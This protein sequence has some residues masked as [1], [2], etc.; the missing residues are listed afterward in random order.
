[1]YSR[2]EG[3]KNVA[4]VKT[5]FFKRKLKNKE[6]KIEWATQES[7]RTEILLTEEPGF[8]VPEDG[9]KTSRIKQVDLIKSVDITNATK[10][11]DLN[12]QFGIYRMNFTRNGRHLLIGGRK[13]H[14][15][16][17]DWITKY[18]HCEMNVMEEVFDVQWLHIETMFAVAQKKWLYIYDNT[19]IELH[20]LKTINKPLRLEFLPYHFLLISGSEEG[21]LTWLDISV[22]SIVSQFNTK[23]GRL[24][25]MKQNPY[26][27]ILC[28]GHSKGIVAMWSPNCKDPVAKILCHRTPLSALAVDP[29]GLYMATSAVDHH[30]NIWDIRNLR[31]P[32]Q[33]YRLHSVASELAFSQRSS[34]ALAMGNIVEIY[35]DCCLTNVKYPYMRHRL[36]S[37]IGNIEFC[38]YEDVLGIGHQSGYTSILIPGSGEPNIDALEC[39]PFQTKKQRQEAEVK[40]LLEKIQPEMI[41]LNPFDILEVNVATSKEKDKARNKSF[42]KKSGHNL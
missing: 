6:K 40:A 13:G 5:K 36:R 42:Q 8:L 30:M 41:S 38:P 18:L 32:L 17:F 15:A 2:G 24:S 37:R 3:L 9:E 31:G 25:I 19:G 11:F 28:T 27:A 39:N 16:S 22:G 34:L 26:N 35:N 12:L 10:Y 4:R 14:V 1:M 33:K 29:K 7:A 23:L 20:C 21:Y